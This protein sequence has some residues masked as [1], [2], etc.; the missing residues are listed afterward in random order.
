MSPSAWVAIV[1]IVV[2]IVLT[3][4]AHIIASVF[5]AGGV[6]ANIKTLL[7]QVGSLQ[8]DV[9]A[10]QATCF[11]KADAAVKM[12]EADREHSHLWDAVNTIRDGKNGGK[13]FTQER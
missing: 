11:T 10:F 3:L 1:A 2:T 5:W 6:S 4:I 8:G 13:S 7:A 9:K 12:A